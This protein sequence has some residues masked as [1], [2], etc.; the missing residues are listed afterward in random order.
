ML[1]EIFTNI[2]R[3]KVARVEGTKRELR[4]V[5]TGVLKLAA[6]RKSLLGDRR[7]STMKQAGLLY[8]RVDG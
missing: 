8:I 3:G 5:Q 1:D 2:L 4:R 6:R 7:I